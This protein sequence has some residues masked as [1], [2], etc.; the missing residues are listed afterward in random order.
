[1]AKVSLPS[2]FEASLVIAYDR[3]VETAW[4]LIR[5]LWSR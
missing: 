3:L 5:H 1:M 4:I 2:S